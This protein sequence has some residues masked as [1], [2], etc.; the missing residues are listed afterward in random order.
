MF[1]GGIREQEHG[2][3]RFRVRQGHNVSDKVQR[4]IPFPDQLRNRSSGRDRPVRHHS[5]SETF[6]TRH[7]LLQEHTKRPNDPSQS[8]QAR[9]Q[10]VHSL[11]EL[12]Q[13][14][15]S[16]GEPHGSQVGQPLR[17]VLEFPLRVHFPTPCDASLEK[18][19]LV[20]R[21]VRT[22]LVQALQDQIPV[23]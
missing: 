23:H 3:P 8:R 14:A 16:L 20:N 18:S 17:I 15:R 4:G 19:A 21:T 13:L 12:H 10:P 7:V 6:G 9:V 5:F 2:P 22:D 1:V 11:Q